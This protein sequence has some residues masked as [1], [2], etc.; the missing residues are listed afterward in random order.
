MELYE[1]GQSGSQ[2]ECRI[3]SLSGFECLAQGAAV[4]QLLQGRELAC[5]KA[6]EFDVRRAPSDE[7]V[8][9][10]RAEIDHRTLI[11]LWLVR[12]PDP[13][14]R[15]VRSH[16]RTRRMQHESQGLDMLRCDLA[17]RIRLER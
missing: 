6:H 14:D 1:A 7:H 17:K 3:G 10:S 2:I 12:K 13:N 9:G 11:R 5:R 8:I 4:R 16:Q 15:I